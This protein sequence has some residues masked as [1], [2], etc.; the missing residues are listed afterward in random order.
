MAPQQYTAGQFISWDLSR[1][2]AVTV[3]LTGVDRFRISY[4]S[5]D[6]VTEAVEATAYRTLAQ[7]TA[8]WRPATP[9][10]I[11]TFERLD[12]PA[13]QNWD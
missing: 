8:D 12:R 10:E 13:P 2:G 6:G 5:W 9:E 4:R 1:D 11:A 3:K 7:Q